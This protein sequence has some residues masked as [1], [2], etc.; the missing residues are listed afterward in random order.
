MARQVINLRKK[1]KIKNNEEIEEAE[2]N[3]ISEDELEDLRFGSYPLP[4]IWI[5]D[6]ISDRTPRIVF[7]GLRMAQMKKLPI[8]IIGISSYGGSVHSALE[9]FDTIES[10]KSNGLA[11]ATVGVGKVMSAGAFLLAAGTKDLR[12]CSE[13]CTL[14]VHEVSA[15][16][17]GKMMDLKVS[18]KETERLSNLYFKIMANNCGKDE[19]EFQKQFLDK[20]DVYLTPTQALEWGIVDRV[21]MPVF[22]I[23]VVPDFNVNIQFDGDKPMVENKVVN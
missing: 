6:E 12:F 21:A 23:N 13:N 1:F 5:D 22:N 20:P 8:A 2:V 14:M 7:N 18:Y 10:F 3:E 4:W 19:A 9:I 11:I 17:E 15:G 16:H